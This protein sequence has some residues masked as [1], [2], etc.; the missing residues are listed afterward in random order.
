M[1]KWE[2]CVINRVASVGIRFSPLDCHIN[3][4]TQDGIKQGEHIKDA[5]GLARKISMLGSEGWEMVGA[6]TVGQGA[7][8]VI[9]FKRLVEA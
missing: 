1:Q 7:S 2:Y 6:G 3:Y 5:D 4:F 9:Y 8:H